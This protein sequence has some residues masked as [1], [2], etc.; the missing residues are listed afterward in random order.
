MH[1]LL[2]L[3]CSSAEDYEEAVQ[4]ELLTK[5]NAIAQW[6]F[7]N[8]RKG[9]TTS[10]QAQKQQKFS[11]MEIHSPDMWCS[12]F[13]LFFFGNQVADLRGELPTILFAGQVEGKKVPHGEATLRS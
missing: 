7:G 1:L 11:M 10:L 8:H 3:Q 12:S 4:W 13:C 9:S 2:L 6:T 5:Q